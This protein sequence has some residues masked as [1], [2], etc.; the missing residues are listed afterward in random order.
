VVKVNAQTAEFMWEGLNPDD[1]E[2]V[3][4]EMQKMVRK[5][6]RSCRKNPAFKGFNDSVKDFANTVP[7]IA[8]LVH[9]SMR[10]R[11]WELTKGIV[12]Q[13]FVLPQNNPE[14]KVG[15]MLALK[16]H[17]FASQLEELSD[18][19]TKEAKM[20]K[21][22]A[23][24]KERWAVVEWWMDTYG[25]DESGS[26]KL[27]KITDD[28]F[29]MLENDQLTIQGMMGSRPQRLNAIHR[30]SIT[31]DTEHHLVRVGDRSTNTTRHC[32]SDTSTTASVKCRG[33][34]NIK[35][36]MNILHRGDRFLR[37]HR[38]IRNGLAELKHGPRWGHGRKVFE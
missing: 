9:P 16:L 31:S 18:Q 34:A 4:K 14:C 12:G 30:R 5:L 7:L 3:S 2:D 15:D 19:S 32:L 22:L 8:I 10:D 1:M 27:L 13:E 21:Q 25:G 28:D 24:L 37:N 38:I 17:L 36:I 35:V 11:H 6:P 33:T 23:D 26:V 29:E 20:E